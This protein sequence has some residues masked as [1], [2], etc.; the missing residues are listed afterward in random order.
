MHCKLYSFVYCIVYIYDI[1]HNSVN[2]IIL[3]TFGSKK[4]GQFPI[5]NMLLRTFFQDF[6]P[7]VTE[8]PST[9]TSNPKARSSPLQSN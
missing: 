1:K 6:F 4:L 8:S 9:L 7:N 2:C 5:L 3:E